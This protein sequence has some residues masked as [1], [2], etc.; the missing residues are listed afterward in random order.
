MT[1]KRVVFVIK[2][3]QEHFVEGGEKK[4][5]WK[6]IQR[7]SFTCH[8]ESMYGVK[9]KNL[10]Y[11]VCLSLKGK[12][13]HIRRNIT[14]ADVWMGKVWFYFVLLTHGVDHLENL[15]QTA[16]VLA[17]LS[18][19]TSWRRKCS[20]QASWMQPFQRA[21][22]NLW[23]KKRLWPNSFVK[24]TPIAQWKQKEKQMEGLP[25]PHM[26]KCNLYLVSF[27]HFNTLPQQAV[28]WQPCLLAPQLL[29]ISSPLGLRSHWV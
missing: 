13:W 1:W 5:R 9:K 3:K 11:V 14:N 19:I 21:A 27:P 29:C 16:F 20:S 24:S 6:D 26:S 18:M 17:V 7:L 28:A 23:C 8:I 10:P 2:W 4:K 25:L 22:W 15:W 12:W